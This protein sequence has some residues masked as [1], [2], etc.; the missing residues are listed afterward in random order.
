MTAPPPGPSTPPPEPTMPIPTGGDPTPVPP[1]GGDPTIPTQGEPYGGGPG[2]PGGTGEDEYEEGDNRRLWLIAGGI[3]VLGLIIG[4]IIAVAA[5]GDDDTTTTT[6][7]SSSSTSTSTSTSTTLPITT[8]AP[9]STAAPA[10]SIT[11]FTVSQNP[12]SCPGTTQVTLSWVTQNTTGVTLSIDNPNGAFGNY[13][14][15]ATEQFPFACGGGP[16]Q[17][18]HTYYLR[19]NGVGGQTTQ[20]QVTVTGNFSQGS[21]ST[22]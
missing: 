1:T 18:Q 16:G 21:T 11:Q 17:V 8:T 7:T 6:T 4:A 15:T 13:G 19:A 20:R 3:L 12:V 14:P 10:P 22:T 9:P 5:S 2:G